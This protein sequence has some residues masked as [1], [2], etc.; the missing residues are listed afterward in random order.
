[1]LRLLFMK[2]GPGPAPLLLR[3]PAK[4]QI[5]SVRCLVNRA[6]EEKAAVRFYG[7]AAEDREIADGGGGIQNKKA[8]VEAG[9]DVIYA[10]TFLA[11]PISLKSHGLEAETCRL[12]ETLVHISREAARGRRR[13]RLPA[14]P[15]PRSN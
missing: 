5:V 1:M 15:V 2:F 4:D 14:D 10:P 8:Y 7:Q 9:S 3:N 11:N 13:S 6:S 12:N